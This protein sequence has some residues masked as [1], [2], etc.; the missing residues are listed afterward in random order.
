MQKRACGHFSKNGILFGK[1]NKG[2][3]DGKALPS[4]I[5]PQ[6]RHC[7]RIMKNV[8]NHQS[9]SLEAPAGQLPMTSGVYLWVLMIM[10]IWASNTVVVKIAVRDLP[11]FWAAFLRFGMALPFMALFIK[12]QGSGFRLHGR[13]WLQ[14]GLLALIFVI[15]IFF[16]N[17][18][19]RFTTGGR[20]SLIIF[21]FPLLVPLVAQLFLKEEPLK[22]K[23]IFGCTIAFCGLLASLWYDL[24]SQTGSTLK[25]DLIELASCLLLAF[26]TV[27]NKRL[28]QSI[29]KWKILFWQMHF[30]LGLFLV[31]ALAYEDLDMTAVRPDA[32]TALIYQALVISVFCFLSW[33]CLIARH[34]SAK[35]SVFFF[36]APLFGMLLSIPLLGERVEPGLLAGCVL[37]GVGIYI[38]NRP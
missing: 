32:W 26:L 22:A 25:G 3:G 15:Q 31:C 28:T 6:K 33:Q 4:N 19:S 2:W 34:N 29:N 10:L 37:V 24:V 30:G 27:Y 12:R 35:M 18:G 7:A 36:A 1:K 38:V 14:V 13:Q 16:L 20:V 8:L 21:S 9:G 11:P 5:D 23:T 17:L